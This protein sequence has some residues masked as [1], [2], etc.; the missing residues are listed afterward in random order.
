MI[1]T[2]DLRLLDSLV[3]R[4][5][6]LPLSDLFTHLFRSTHRTISVVTTNYDR[7]A[8]YAAEFASYEFFDG[9]TNRHFR[10][11]RGT[12]PTNAQSRNRERCVNI[13]KV[14][15]SVDWFKNNLNTPIALPHSEDYPEQCRPLLVTP[16]ITKYFQ[17]HLE[18]FRS[19]MTN[20]DQA[21]ADARGF[22]CIGY[23]FAD[24]H[25][26]PKLIERVASTQAPV[27][28]LARTLREGA[29]RFL[30][31]CMHSNMLALEKN[32]DGTMVYTSRH[33][34]GALLPNSDLW[35]LSGFLTLLRI[36]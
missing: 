36:P 35:S 15:G 19:I 24:S 3:S 5:T 4:K 6:H 20:A 2:D 1:V 27:A 21:L 16:G 17:T 32:G 14:H 12:L 18:P 34:D 30:T 7:V 29:K 25:I 10:R 33:H 8:E 31:N 28:I 13:W 9:F 22:I 11:F 26:E 23:G